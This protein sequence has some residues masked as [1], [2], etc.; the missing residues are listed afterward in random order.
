MN[1]RILLLLL[2]PFALTTMTGCGTN[3]RKMKLTFGTYVTTSDNSNPDT[4]LISYDDLS[5]KMSKNSSSNNENFLL[6]IPDP[7]GSCVCWSTFQP[8]LKQFI[9][10]TNYRIYQVNQSSFGENDDRFGLSFKKGYVTFAIIEGTTIKQQYPD[11]H[12]F[13]NATGLKAE[14]DKYVTAPDMYYV[15][16][17]YLNDQIKIG[18]TV[19]VSYVRSGCGDCQYALPNILVPYTYVQGY[20][21]K[22]FLIDLQELY[23]KDANSYQIFMDDF[24][25]SEKYN[26][27]FGYGK[28]F[29]PTTQYYK[30]GILI[31]ASVYFNDEISLID[32]KY[33]ITNSFYDEHRIEHLKY[34]TGVQ[35]K[36][37]KGKELPAKEV[38]SYTDKEGGVHY[39]WNQSDADN[40]HRPLLEAFLNKYSQ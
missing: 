25:L 27:E 20:K 40:Y 5:L 26:V 21:T 22:L 12:V 4:T 30:N 34:L 11:S 8:I 14:I 38:K 6:V 39:F 9:K 35:T 16:Q 7:E 1:K 37:L 24:N 3:I 31:D 33:V 2:A 10:E 32:G 17:D 13:N 19:L 28:G 18:N 36:I 29:V 15:S 23:E